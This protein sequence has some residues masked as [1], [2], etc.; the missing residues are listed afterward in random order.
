VRDGGSREAA[1]LHATARKQQNE[2]WD[3]FRDRRLR[4][5]MKLT[6]TARDNATQA[7]RMSQGRER[8]PD[9]PRGGRPRRG[10]P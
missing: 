7:A 5:A 8:A 4:F 3:A 9:R 2:A 6:M 1:R 10:A